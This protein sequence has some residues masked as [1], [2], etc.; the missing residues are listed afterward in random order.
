MTFSAVVLPASA[1]HSREMT[2]PSTAPAMHA[3][4]P[5]RVSG[6]V[7]RSTPIAIDTAPS[8]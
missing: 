3:R 2:K 7:A 5:A 1:Q 6:T 8:A 4:R